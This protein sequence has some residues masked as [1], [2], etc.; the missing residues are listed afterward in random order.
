[1][2]DIPVV[3][4]AFANNYREESFLVNLAKERDEIIEILRT[5]K[6]KALCDY[7]I[8]EDANIK[9]VAK[10]FNYWGSK[11]RVSIFHFAGHANDY[12]LCFNSFK[13]EP[14]YI[15]A[16]G[17]AQFLG[18]QDDLKLVFLNGCATQEHANY[19]HE[20]GIPAVISTIR[21][22]NDSLAADMAIEFYRSLSTDKTI[23]N[24]FLEAEGIVKAKNEQW[25][26]FTRGLGFN[27]DNQKNDIWGLTSFPN[28]I[29]PSGWSF[30]K[31]KDD[32][33][34]GLP[35]VETSI[36]PENPFVGLK[37][38]TAAYANAFWG[39]GQ[40]IR[41]FFYL[42]DKVVSPSIFICHG[43]KGVGKS[44][45][46]KAGV[47]PR[48][49]NKYFTRIIHLEKNTS[50]EGFKNIIV[51]CLSEKI[52]MKRKGFIF[53]FG[54]SKNH[55]LC[56]DE[57]KK[58]FDRKI[59]GIN[60]VLELSNSLLSDWMPKFNNYFCTMYN[61]LP[62]DK[63]RIDSI[64][65]G[66]E[67]QYNVNITSRFQESFTS[68]VLSDS[69][70]AIA[71]IIQFILFELCQ[72]AIGK[73]FGR[74]YFNLELLTEWNE[75]GGFSNYINLQLSKID[76]E[77]LNSGL[78]LE[79]LNECAPLNY[80]NSIPDISKLDRLFNISFEELEKIVF[81]LKNCYLISE[82]VALERSSFSN[83][84]LY[85]SILINPLKDILDN[86]FRPAQE[87]RR[88]CNYHSQ[89]EKYLDESQLALIKTNWNFVKSFNKKELSVLQK[90]KRYYGEIKNRKK[91]VLTFQICM[92]FTILIL[93][94][95]LNSPYLIMY[96]VLIFILYIF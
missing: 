36:L 77:Y 52:L 14:E 49:E 40:E 56:L 22:V 38:Y 30:S 65:T 70:S 72:I 42:L 19:L 47:I 68:I 23:W 27:K 46:L 84:R 94:V 79:I 15:Y 4:L 66:F 60:F 39:R 17:F 85:H 29:E 59:P 2:S 20:K 61:L 83:I 62:L 80:L 31:V 5:A 37:E 54:L 93:G 41:D 18:Q 89:R 81:Q 45:L 87:V 10:A 86:S 95:Y 13:G 67:N 71:P 63:R 43:A 88:I 48:I 28:K 8:I 91:W 16:E 3:L 1:M 73:H 7:E 9:K 25:S 90:S 50:A 33:L 44:S 76:L 32:P 51:Q 26:V 35:L 69:K 21:E 96:L 78:V 64:F 12:Q 82:P 34:L 53:V 57:I 6:D 55:E 74:P 75:N 92:L 24:A 58:G 11:G